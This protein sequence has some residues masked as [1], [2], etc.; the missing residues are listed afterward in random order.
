MADNYAQRT[1]IAEAPR[2]ASEADQIVDQLRCRIESYRKVASRLQAVTDKIVGPRPHGVSGSIEAATPVAP[3]VVSNLR[4]ID[5]ELAAVCDGING[6]IE[7]LE[8]FA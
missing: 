4:D 2:P 8:S 7:T 3:N 1:G 5:R 6:Y